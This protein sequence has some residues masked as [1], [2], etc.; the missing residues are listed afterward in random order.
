MDLTFNQR[1]AISQMISALSNRGWQKMETLKFFSDYRLPVNCSELPAYTYYQLLR[2]LPL[3][4]K[5]NIIRRIFQAW[6]ALHNYND[7]AIYEAFSMLIYLKIC[8]GV[9]FFF[10]NSLC[11]LRDYFGIKGIKGESF[12]DSHYKL[13]YEN[14]EKQIEYI[15]DENTNKLKII[16]DGALLNE[17]APFNDMPTQ[18]QKDSLMAC[19]TDLQ[20]K[21]TMRWIYADG[22][23]EYQYKNNARKGYVQITISEIDYSDNNGVF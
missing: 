19:I 15:L 20:L 23:I 8:S 17:K 12:D 1:K 4:V 6:V 9:E 2:E 16:I 13:Y 21:G 18:K 3:S 10:M 7:F 14:S 5:R 11:S 22:K